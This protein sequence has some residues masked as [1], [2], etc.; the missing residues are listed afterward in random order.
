MRFLLT[1][2]IIVAYI[3]YMVYE[4][5]NV[6]LPDA[7]SKEKLFTIATGL[8]V[9][10]TI[11]FISMS[12][13]HTYGFRSVLC[14]IVAAFGLFG[15]VVSLFFTLPKGTYAE[16]GKR[17]RTYKR[18]MYALCRH[19][20]VLFYCIFYL[21]LWLAMPSPKGLIECVV[22]ILGDVAYMLVQDLWSFPKIFYDYDQYKKQTP[23]FIPNGRSIRRCIK[24][25]T[26][27][28]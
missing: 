22:F 20:G 7:R 10:A 25:Y 11:A 8:L 14:F 23:M 6:Q 16:P 19:P 3:I 4:W 28:R 2:L 1:I 24:T 18:K 21:F 17:R 26:Y 12:Y 5:C 9:V 15:M 13:K 27:R